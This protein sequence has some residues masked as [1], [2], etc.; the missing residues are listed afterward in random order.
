MYLCSFT[1][2]THWVLNNDAPLGG[3]EK[4]LEMFLLQT[5]QDIWKKLNLN[6]DRSLIWHSREGPE[7]TM[8]FSSCTI[9]GLNM[10]LSAE[11]RY[12]ISVQLKNRI[13]VTFSKYGSMFGRMGVCACFCWGGT[14]CST[15]AA[16]FKWF[17]ITGAQRGICQ[18]LVVLRKPCKSIRLSQHAP[19]PHQWSHSLWSKCP[20]LI[21][22][23][24]EVH[25]SLQKVHTGFDTFYSWRSFASPGS[26]FRSRFRQSCSESMGC[27]FCCHMDILIAKLRGEKWPISL[28][29][30]TLRLPSVKSDWWSL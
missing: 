7:C 19:P 14:V 5:S 27:G 17:Q 9:H 23:F 24:H 26:F 20:P 12:F 15:P 28:S 8:N 10:A 22:G 4:M 25:S 21:G 16:W 11:R 18:L 13:N 3:P 30:V 2:C 29:H 1:V 6:L